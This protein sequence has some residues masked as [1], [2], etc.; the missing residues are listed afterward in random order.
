M[1]EINGKEYEPK[2]NIQFADRLIHDYAVKNSK[3]QETLDG[4]SHFINQLIDN[5]PEAITNAYRYALDVPDKELPSLKDVAKGLEKAGIYKQEDIFSELFKKI[6]DN[7]FL[8]LK[9][10]AF[11]KSR[12]N[13]VD[14]SKKVLNGITD[15]EQKQSAMIELKSAEAGLSQIQKQLKQLEK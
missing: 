4:F 6:K 10:K 5:E 12:Q 8:A 15:K 3:E 11:L 14:V 13:I 9:L 2:F 1:L 7:G